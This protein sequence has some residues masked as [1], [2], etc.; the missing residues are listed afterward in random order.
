MKIL[1]A[2]NR[3]MIFAAGG[4]LAAMV[5]LTMSDVFMRY[6]FDKPIIGTTEITELMMICVAF[7]GLGWCAVNRAHLKVDLIMANRSP[8]T[9]AI[10]DSIT[11]IS[12]L[13]LCVFITWRCFVESV[14]SMQLGVTFSLLDLPDY[15]FYFILTL[16]FASLCVVMVT[17][18][19]ENIAKA[20]KA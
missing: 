19:I 12:G 17:N 15:P 5:L 3:V 18:V 2:I 9:Q 6:V 14:T 1:T 10:V 8:R 4:V 11:L 16:G 13:C 20:V 7:L